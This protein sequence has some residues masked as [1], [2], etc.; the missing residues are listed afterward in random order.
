MSFTLAIV[1]RPNVGK[2]TLLNQLVGEKLAIITS[3]AQT[4]RHRIHGIVS[5]EDYQLVFSDTPGIV[6][7][8]YKLHQTMLDE[9]RNALVDA[10]VLL[11]ITEI[12]EKAFKNADLEAIINKL[13]I[14]VLVLV[15]KID[16]SHQD[17]L[18]ATIQK[19]SGIF[20]RAEVRPI[21][22]LHGFGVVELKNKLLELLP[23][24]PAFY[25][26]ED[27]TDKSERFIVEEII[28][29][30]ILI[31]FK[32]EI[33]YAVEIVVESFKEVDQMIHIHANIIVER[34]TQRGIIIGHEGKSL[35]RIGTE[36][37]RDI[38]KF[39]G[40]KVFLQLYVKVDKDWRKSDAKLKKY[41]YLK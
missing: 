17:E 9:V 6:D 14:P 4:T 35:K 8:A 5:G 18:E 1:G 29:E 38:E 13:E 27:L 26:K 7:P 36:A 19:W 20:P 10:D 12:G 34:A 31:H 33:P 41:G 30:K 22:A 40:A 37:R 11:I 23:E 21:S 25:N 2:S 16:L 28:R 32:K 3:K 15:N 24:S 39:F